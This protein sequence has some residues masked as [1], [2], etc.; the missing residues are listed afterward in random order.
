MRPEIILYILSQ[1]IL[2]D[3]VISWL[4]AEAAKTDTPIDDYFVDFLCIAL[5][6]TKTF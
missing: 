6:K 3:K 5:S 4:R 2:N 1:L